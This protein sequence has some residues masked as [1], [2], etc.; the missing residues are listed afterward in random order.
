S[1]SSDAVCAWRDRCPL[2][3]S[4]PSSHR[5][6]HRNLAIRALTLRFIGKASASVG[7]QDLLHGVI[8]GAMVLARLNCVV[9][10][11]ALISGDDL[12]RKFAA[13]MHQ[14]ALLK[15]TITLDHFLR[16]LIKRTSVSCANQQKFRQPLVPVSDCISERRRARFTNTKNRAPAPSDIVPDVCL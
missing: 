10:S 13:E 9:R 4:S 7:D 16:E 8:L 6:Q 12:D 5:P 14:L 15:C 11:R 3:S 1:L 2:L